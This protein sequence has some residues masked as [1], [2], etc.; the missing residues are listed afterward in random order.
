MAQPGTLFVMARV[1]G[2]VREALMRPL[3]D[4]G[5]DVSLGRRISPLRNWHQTLSDLHPPEAR[6][7]MRRACAGIDA[8]AFHMQLD[9]LQSAGAPPRRVLWLYLP[10]RGKPDDLTRLQASV[11][12][13]LCANGIVDTQ[14]HRAHVTVSYN[15]PQEIAPLDIAPVSWQVDAIELVEVAGQ[16]TDYRYQVVEAWPLHAPAAPPPLQLGLLG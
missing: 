5:L 3:A 9:R 10:T 12:E 8:H 1:P 16:G 2:E 14:G 7:A 15:A 11:R 6:E 13:K 4:R